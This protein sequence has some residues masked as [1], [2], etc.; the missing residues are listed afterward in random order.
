[1]ARLGTLTVD[2]RNSKRRLLRR[3]ALRPRAF[4]AGCLSEP[5]S[6][7]A[8]AMRR[9]ERV[10]ALLSSQERLVPGVDLVW[11]A[12]ANGEAEERARQEEHRRQCHHLHGPQAGRDGGGQRRVLRGR[13]EVGPPPGG[14]VPAAG[15][16]D[17][18]RHVTWGRRVGLSGGL[19]PN[20]VD[21]V[22]HADHLRP[23][24]WIRPR[25]ADLLVVCAL[26]VVPL[27]DE[28][29]RQLPPICDDPLLQ[30]DL[31]AAHL[32][33]AGV[34]RFQ[35]S[36]LCVQSVLP[37]FLP[38]LHVLAIHTAVIE[39]H[40]VGDEVEGP[41]SG[42]AREVCVRS[43]VHQGGQR[44]APVVQRQIHRRFGGVR[45]EPDL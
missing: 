26:K 3:P 18:G 30:G 39:L 15:E 8:R 13:G 34:P 42:L 21:V 2:G 41:E 37:R 44:A 32:L 11:L 20:R 40:P 14:V 9:G 45:C 12:P 25:G 10:A 19:D 22:A 23:L 27:H 28:G 43:G 6:K 36:K 29:I 31:P 1:M 24:F 17:H 16:R 4:F 35:R 7:R 33:C 38:R 5:A